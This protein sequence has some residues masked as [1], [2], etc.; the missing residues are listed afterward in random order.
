MLPEL[1]KLLSIS[2]LRFQ[3]LLLVSVLAENL[4]KSVLMQ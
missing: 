2:L 3:K 4:F 1:Q